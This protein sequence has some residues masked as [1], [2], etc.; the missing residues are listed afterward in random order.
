MRRR[1]LRIGFSVAAAAVLFIMPVGVA[2]SE[3]L[4]RTV[5]ATVSGPASVTAR[6]GE[7]AAFTLTMTAS[8]A[9]PCDFNG[10]A[11]AAVQSRYTGMSRFS[12]GWFVG[13][14]ELTSVS[15]TPDLACQAT[16]PGAPEAATIQA[17]FFAQ[18]TMA[19]GSYTL[20]LTGTV[21]GAPMISVTTPQVTFIVEDGNCAPL[22]TPDAYSVPRG[23]TLTVG[24]PGVLDNDTDPDGDGLEAVLAGSPSH[25][26]LS[27]DADGSFS[28]IPS[29]TFVG[30]DSFTYRASDGLLESDVTT[31]DITVTDSSPP[32]VAYTLA[33]ESP[34]DGK[35]YR[36]SVTLT[37]QV[38]DLES[39]VTKTGCVDQVLDS[40]QAMTAYS[41]TATSAGGT[42]GPITVSLGF[43]HTAPT[44]STSLGDDTRIVLGQ[45][46]PV[47]S[48]ADVVDPD[49]DGAAG[50]V[51]PSGVDATTVQCENL[52]VSSVG[53]RTATCSASDH[54]GN[55]ATAT[56]SYVVTHGFGGFTAP[57]PRASAKKGSTLPVKFTVT[58][59]DGIRGFTALT[60]LRARMVGPAT[61]SAS[62]GYVATIAAY[63]CDLKTPRTSGTYRLL[64]E[65]SVV[66]PDGVAWVALGDSAS[67]AGAMAGND[68]EIRLR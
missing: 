22:T 63:Q 48:A 52:D 44:L 29:R 40:E 64:V 28:Y 62:C 68:L 43:D 37:W 41:C 12:G 55:S 5:A 67:V 11:W 35:W 36:Q 4:A 59:F 53:S 19:P 1:H 18:C 51:E 6:Q 8:G 61:A 24:A 30:A 54:A 42:T 56:A 50:P 25:G 17:S 33:P 39:D 10:S 32:T 46:A 66:T 14:S 2:A 26:V 47:L 21:S 7:T 58:D 20:R 15:F 65:Q 27:L 57:L 23:G 34:G 16:W 49:P 60:G 9:L 31:V 13:G 45:T 3:P 38:A